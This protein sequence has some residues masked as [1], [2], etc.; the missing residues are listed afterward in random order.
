VEWKR[1]GC[2]VGMRKEVGEDVDMRRGIEKRE[3]RVKAI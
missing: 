3:I 2:V 1:I